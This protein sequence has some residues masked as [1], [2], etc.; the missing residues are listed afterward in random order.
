MYMYFH[1]LSHFVSYI[2]GSKNFVS[3]RKQSTRSPTRS[4]NS[5]EPCSPKVRAYRRST[6]DGRSSSV[7]SSTSSVMNGL[8]DN[9]IYE[10]L[11]RDEEQSISK[12]NRAFMKR[13]EEN[14]TSGQSLF[15]N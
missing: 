1:I 15:I 7:S 3:I 13:N 6:S 2:L 4:T 14:S 8:Q 11:S 9:K 5:V 12:E 10:Q